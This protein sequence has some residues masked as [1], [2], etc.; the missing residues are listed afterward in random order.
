MVGWKRSKP[1]PNFAV[2]KQWKATFKDDFKVSYAIINCI[3]MRQE[4]I[5][6][7][8]RKE[9]N[10]YLTRYENVFKTKIIYT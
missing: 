1:S 6:L 7:K 5:L 8:E 10:I 9:G 3:Y 4:T 2:V